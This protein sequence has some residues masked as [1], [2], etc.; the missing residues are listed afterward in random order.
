MMQQ[1]RICLLND[2]NMLLIFEDCSTK[3]DK[4]ICLILEHLTGL[5]INPDLNLSKYICSNCLQQLEN[6]Y[7]F[8]DACIKAETRLI[9]DV[10]IDIKDVGIDIIED[11]GIDIQDAPEDYDD[12]VISEPKARKTRV[13]ITNLCNI[14]GK[15]FKT[16][17][18]L[19]RHLNK[20]NNIKP[21]ACRYCDNKLSTPYSLKMH[22]RIHTNEKP[23][24]CTICTKAFRTSFQLL[25]HIRRHSKILPFVCTFEGCD[26]AYPVS[27]ELKDHISY[28][29]KG[30]RSYQC[31]LCE[32][33]YTKKQHL[34]KHMESHDSTKISERTFGC[35]L[36]GKMFY[37]ST[38][39]NKH[40]KCVHGVFRRR[41]LEPAEILS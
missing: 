6:A 16:R 7:A 33:N 2:T 29:H 35:H 22:E 26:K 38:I 18:T 11:A 24:P 1:C 41:A 13:R 30:E 10:K 19:T 39:L 31:D 28:Y 3:F 32:K 37:K 5:C 36:C 17:R 8:R 25:H 40:L 12:D 23:H 14:C 9:E 15:E 4:Q 20:H 27:T 21:Y 34:K